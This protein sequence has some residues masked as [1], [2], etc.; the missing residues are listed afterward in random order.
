MQPSPE[1]QIQPHLTRGERLLWSGRP[2]KGIGLQGTDFIGFGMGAVGVVFMGGSIVRGIL[3]GDFGFLIFL[4]PFAT[5]WVGIAAGQPFWRARRRRNVVYAL[6]DRRALIV[7]EKASSEV[8]SVSLL[9]QPTVTLEAHRDGTGTILFGNQSAV[10][11]Q[12]ETGPAFRRVEN[13]S[14]VYILIQEIQTHP[15]TEYRNSA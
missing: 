1:M 4:V 10:E 5:V 3:D 2:R 13:V 14:A 11:R 6:T 12:Q 9:A 7:L 15:S 8:Q